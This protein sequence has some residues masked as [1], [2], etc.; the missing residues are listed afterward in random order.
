MV[1]AREESQKRKVEKKRSTK[2][3]EEKVRESQR[4]EGPGGRKCSKWTA[5]FFQW[6][7]HFWENV[8]STPCSDHY[9]K[10]R[11][12]KYTMPWREA[13]VEI[14][15]P[16][17]TC[18]DMFGPFLDAWQSPGSLHFVK[19]KTCKCLRSFNYNRYFTLQYFT[20]HYFT[21]HYIK[22]SQITLPHTTLHYTTAATATELP[23]ATLHYLH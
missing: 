23:Y 13:R 11:C 12:A 19:K 7:A 2:R 4:R 5:L 20:L 14:N 15:V 18:L 8:Q 10:L 1:R 17:T 9:W 3:C 6:L 22:V 16:N 21:L